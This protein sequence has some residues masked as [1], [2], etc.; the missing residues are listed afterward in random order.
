MRGTD[1]FESYVACQIKSLENTGKQKAGVASP[2]VTISRQAGAGGITIG[3]KLVAY[4]WE[5]DRGSGC[6]WAIFDKTLVNRVLEEHHLPEKIS[7]YMPESKVSQVDDIMEELFNLHPSEWTLIHKTS[8]TILKLAQMG[9]VILV[10]RGSNIVARS[11]ENGFHVRL[12]AS[13]EKRI[14]H[15]QE[16]YK[17]DRKRALKFM[18]KEDKGRRDYVKEYFDKNIDDPL[19]YDLVINTDRI[20][21]DQAAKLIA[22]EV[23]EIKKRISSQ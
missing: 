6:P 17:L 7:Q 11:L 3:E 8:E 1:I 22:R 10:G 19:L 18:E 20:S 23:L 21:Y 9:N 14:E 4:L 2:F 16:Y 12:I 13:P 15:L 5:N